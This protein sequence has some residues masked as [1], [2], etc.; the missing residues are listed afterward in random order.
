MI[1]SAR[2]VIPGGSVKNPFSAG[3]YSSTQKSNEYLVALRSFDHLD[4]CLAYR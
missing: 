1:T 2:A 3:V 4:P